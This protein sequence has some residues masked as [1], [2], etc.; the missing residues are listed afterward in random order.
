MADADLLQ[1]AQAWP[2]LA[3]QQPHRHVY[4]TSDP[5]SPRHEAWCLLGS[6]FWSSWNRGW[7]SRSFNFFISP[8]PSVTRSRFSCCSLG[9][10]IDYHHH[11]V[12]EWNVHDYCWEIYTQNYL[13]F[14]HISYILCCNNN[15][16]G[17][18]N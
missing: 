18:K 6:W 17:T 3:Y 4:S 16:Y 10:C 8:P 5:R 14:I 13:L 7:L 15:W 2:L 11:Q 12:H 1:R 9:C